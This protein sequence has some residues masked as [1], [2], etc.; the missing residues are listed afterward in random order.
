MCRLKRQI[1]YSFCL[2][3]W[4]RYYIFW[5]GDEIEQN[6]L[7]IPD[8]YIEATYEEAEKAKKSGSSLENFLGSVRTICRDMSCNRLINLGKL[9]DVLFNVSEI[10][11]SRFKTSYTSELCLLEIV[12]EMLVNRTA[13]TQTL[14]T[15]QIKRKYATNVSFTSSLSFDK[16]QEFGVGIKATAGFDFFAKVQ[17]ELSVNHAYNLGTFESNSTTKSN[18]KIV[19][20]PA[21]EVSLESQTQVNITTQIFTQKVIDHYLIDLYIDNIQIDDK[22]PYN[23][24]NMKCLPDFGKDEIGIEN[25]DGRFILTNIP[26]VVE[27]TEY[28]DKLPFAEVTPIPLQMNSEM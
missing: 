21:Q 11:C 4:G 24:D 25:R 17:L 16:S 2:P 23:F 7:D 12:D 9:K 18:E 1:Y 20:V 5:D 6:I 15:N 14:K 8:C 13:T 28:I 22:L 19:T 10:A 26:F 27:R 3:Y